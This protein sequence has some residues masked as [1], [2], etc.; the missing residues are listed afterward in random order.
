MRKSLLT[1]VL[2][3]AVLVALSGCGGGGDNSRPEMTTA[4]TAPTATY[5]PLKVGNWW[6]Y[7]IGA[8]ATLENFRLS[9]TTT[10]GGA[11]YFV[12]AVVRPGGGVP[13]LKS[14]LYRHAA[15]GLHYRAASAS[16]DTL[17]L[18]PPLTAGTTWTSEGRA[19][20]LV[21]DAA[22]LSTPAG[23]FGPC[24]VVEET[25]GT[26]KVRTAYAAG[27]GIVQ[28]TQGAVTL[29][30]LDATSLQGVGAFLSSQ[31]VQAAPGLAPLVRVRL[32]LPADQDTIH[33]W[34]VYRAPSATTCPVEAAHLVDMLTGSISSYSDDPTRND[35]TQDMRMSFQYLSGGSLKSA[36]VTATFNHPAMTPGVRYFH[37]VKPIIDPAVAS[38]LAQV[39][40]TPAITGKPASVL[41]G[42][43]SNT[44][45]PVTF[46]SPPLQLTPVNGQANLPPSEIT[47]NWQKSVGANEYVVQVFSDS[48]PQGLLAPV[49]SSPLVNATGTSSL[50]TTITGPFATGTA[51]YWR[52]GARQSG[53]PLAPLNLQTGQSGWLYSTMRN[54]TTAVAPPPPPA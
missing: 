24:L 30:S 16:A 49:F 1:S 47:F 34:L 11:S 13:T 6:H 36:S 29:L 39:I 37:R 2:L 48:D 41:A 51:Y 46:F 52:V 35:L 15:D 44:S 17:I 38:G 43:P 45:G 12:A 31:L 20:K 10:A 18:K 5:L 7:K 33:G 23:V 3:S 22:M 21:Q 54:F 50:G 9:G 53:D 40:V 26:K 8:T 27:L 14:G 28:V 4:A 32:K 19:F 25:V 42:K